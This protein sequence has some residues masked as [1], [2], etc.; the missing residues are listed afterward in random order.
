MVITVTYLVCVPP[1]PHS[2]H[3]K[4]L[5]KLEERLLS[6]LH[7]QK[8]I[9]RRVPSCVQSLAMSLA[10]FSLIR[11]SAV[12]VVLALGNRCLIQTRSLHSVLPS[13]PRASLVFVVRSSLC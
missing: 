12:F 1:L 11:P 10:R 4:H 8:K 3:L 6:S 2:Y 9:L 13:S 7:H 5:P